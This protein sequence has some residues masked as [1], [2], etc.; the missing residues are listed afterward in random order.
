MSSATQRNHDKAPPKPRPPTT[1]T[2]FPKASAESPH[3]HTLNTTH[4]HG[5]HN[6][7]TAC[8]ETHIDYKYQ[9]MATCH[10]T[11]DLRNQISVYVPELMSDSHIQRNETVSES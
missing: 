5:H 10:S 11:T 7:I 4:N 8:H 9:N 3:P 1:T 6:A 2:N